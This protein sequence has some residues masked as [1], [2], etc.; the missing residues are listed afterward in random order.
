MV[1]VPDLF[2]VSYNG[3]PE[4]ILHPPQWLRMAAFPEPSEENLYWVEHVN[5]L[6][7]SFRQLVGRDLTDSTLSPIEAA[8]EIYHAPFVVVS[9]DTAADPIFN[10]GNRAAQ[11]LFEMNW[12]EF[13]ALPSRQSAEPPNR[14][15]R[16][17]LLAAVSTQGFIENY[18][19]TR[20]AK[21]GKR[22]RIEQVTVWNLNANGLYLGQAAVYSQWRYL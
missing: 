3:S 18:A 12:Q 19:G 1:C 10:Y 9:H 4:L 7:E 21:S 22:F 14:E 20:I 5:L 8:T 17:Q 2:S 15:E 11:Q 16:A 13:T 6:R